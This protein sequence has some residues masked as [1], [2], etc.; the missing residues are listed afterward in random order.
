MPKK[1]RV[2][3]MWLDRGVVGYDTKT[4]KRL[5]A[6]PRKKSLSGRRSMSVTEFE[7]HA[8][9]KKRGKGKKHPT[10]Y[11]KPSY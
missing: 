8:A 1:K 6:I 5:G 2:E 10:L 4:K 9:I 11:G 7:K 3:L